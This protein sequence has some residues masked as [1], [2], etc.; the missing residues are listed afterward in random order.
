MPP[1]SSQE[2]EEEKR[3]GEHFSPR[4]GSKNNGLRAIRV[5]KELKVN[6]GRLA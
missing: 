6:L 5:D 1:H 4:L 3:E 2:L